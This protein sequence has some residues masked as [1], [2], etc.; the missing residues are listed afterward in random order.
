ML[1]VVVKPEFME[2]YLNVRRRKQDFEPGC[3]V[4]HGLGADAAHKVWL[5]RCKLGNAEGGFG[6]GVGEEVVEAH[7]LRR[8]QPCPAHR[9]RDAR[10]TRT[11]GGPSAEKK[12]VGTQNGVGV[13][14]AVLRGRRKPKCA[15]V[16][17]PYEDN[18]SRETFAPTT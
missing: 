15:V 16:H 4:D 6:V 10:A 3:R 17:L 14:V 12:L 11:R 18:E 1:S 2:R 13:D 5:H 7:A 8:R 9:R